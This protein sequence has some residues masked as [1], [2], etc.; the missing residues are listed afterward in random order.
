MNML[1]LAS[2]C[3]ENFLSSF[4][5]CVWPSDRHGT[6]IDIKAQGESS[7]FIGAA[8]F[9]YFVCF[10]RLDVQYRAAGGRPMDQ[11]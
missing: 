8:I 10:L 5:K 7:E 6:L 11:A 1:D 4:C 3:F 2:I 9:L